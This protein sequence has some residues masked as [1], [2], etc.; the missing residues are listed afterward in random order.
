MVVDA[1]RDSGTSREYVGPTRVKD[2]AVE[3]QD[4]PPGY[5]WAGLQAYPVEEA[6]GV[7]RVS[8]PAVE[9]H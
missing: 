4:E 8:E 7:T 2:P 3:M 1:V 5:W 6:I 9:M